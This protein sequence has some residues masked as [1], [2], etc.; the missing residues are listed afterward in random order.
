MGCDGIHSRTRRSI[1]P[2]APRPLY[3][4]IMDSGG[5]T[6]TA[7][8]PPS[9]GVMRM[10]FGTKGFFGYQVAPSGEVY[11]FENFQH[12]SEPDREELE[13]ITDSRWRQK[14]LGLHRQDHSPI[15]EIIRSTAEIGRWPNHEMPSLC[16]WHQGPVCL[17]GDAAHAMLPSAGQGASMAMEDAIVLA[18]CLR[19]MPRVQEAFPAFEQ[20]RRGRVEHAVEVARKNGSRKAPT[21]ALTRA[22][23]DLVLPFFLRMGV[24]N[25]GR[26]Y[27]YTV[28]WD[29]KVAAV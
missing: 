13:A 10:T 9:D 19:D 4:G 20:L 18:K 27:S 3:T 16:S 11:W 17:I 12:T 8:V 15:S 22:I 1:M 28:D 23:R 21:N 14:L 29:E 25:A 26:A 24:K 7:G 5:Y 6:R 2:D